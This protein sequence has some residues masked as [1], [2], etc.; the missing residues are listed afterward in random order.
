MTVSQTCELRD[1]ATVNIA[2]CP[3]SL[4]VHL[5]MGPDHCAL[6]TVEV[7]A[8]GASKGS[9]AP[10]DRSQTGTVSL[11]RFAAGSTVKVAVQATGIL[12]GCNT[13]TIG[14][15]AASGSIDVLVAP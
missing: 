12:G 14:N 6:A 10:L 15:W 13:G 5:T 9:T 3:K 7:F 1:V 2:G 11:G 4:E 8:N